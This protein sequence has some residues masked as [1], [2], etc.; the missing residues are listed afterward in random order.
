MV[1]KVEVKEPIEG[2]CDYKEVYTMLPMLGGQTEANA[3][4][5]KRKL[6]AVWIAK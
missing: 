3:R 1:A 6:Q 2:L 4:Y 5:L